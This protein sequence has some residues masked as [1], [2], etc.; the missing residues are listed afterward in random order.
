[1]T[2]PQ[3][4]SRPAFSNTS[5]GRAAVGTPLLAED[6]LLL[7][8]QPDSGSIAGEGTLFYVLAGAV[9]ADL[10][11]G[12]H[13]RTGTGLTGTM[14]V[15]AVA[16]NPPADHLLRTS[17]DH[18]VERSRGLQTVLAALGP[19]L[20]EPLL[21]RL[22]ERGDIH[23]VARKVLGLFNTSVLE[24]GDSGRRDGLLADVRAVLVDGSEATPRVASRRSRPSCMQAGRFRSSTA[25]SRGPLR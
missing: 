10:G 24:V 1:M 25:T 5:D 6:L 8:F 14:K 12:E 2:A 11:L 16:E 13:V 21:E 4:D 15:Q 23:R 22:V 20:R 18:V 19:P 3:G 7:L 9:L 17:W